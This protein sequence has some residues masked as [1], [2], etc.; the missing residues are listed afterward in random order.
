MNGDVLLWGFARQGESI[1]RSPY[2]DHSQSKEHKTLSANSRGAILR[3][4]AVLSMAAGLLTAPWAGCATSYKTNA[5][6]TNAAPTNSVPD[7]DPNSVYAKVYGETMVPRCEAKTTTSCPEG[8]VFSERYGM[9]AYPIGSAEELMELS[10]RWNDQGKAAYPQT[11]CDGNPAFLLT[12]DIDLGRFGD[13]WRP[14]GAGRNVFEGYFLGDDH[15]IKARLRDNAGLFASVS[16]ATIQDFALEIAAVGSSRYFLGEYVDHSNYRNIVLKGFWDYS[17][18]ETRSAY[19]MMYEVDHSWLENITVDLDARFRAEA[20]MW[21]S[22]GAKDIRSSVVK[23]LT[24]KGNNTLFK[25]DYTYS[26]GGIAYHTENS[27]Y[28]DIEIDIGLDVSRSNR[29]KYDSDAY[30]L[31]YDVNN[32]VMDI[33]NIRN[34][35]IKMD[36]TYALALVTLIDNVQKDS[37]CRITNLLDDTDYKGSDD[38]KSTIL[39]TTNNKSKLTVAN[40]LLKG[41]YTKVAD[42]IM[43]QRFAFHNVV[44]TRSAAKLASD[45]PLPGTHIYAMTDVESGAVNADMMNRLLTDPSASLPAGQYLRWAQDAMGRLQLLFAADSTNQM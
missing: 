4:A 18:S 31:F 40:A 7:W 15:V 8:Q 42:S 39:R 11:Q 34:A 29:E 2:R 37:T 30:I 43:S 21:V 23:Q 12:A 28:N 44:F 27:I 5:A 16:Y 22:T 35:R 38:L 10:V 26:Y 33:V 14:I 6:T 32:V 13:I 25:T 24:I 36:E 45:K 3:A 9:C 1:M 20:N 17:T 41:R 19:A